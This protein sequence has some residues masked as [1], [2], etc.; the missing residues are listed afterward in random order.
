MEQVRNGPMAGRTV[1]VTGGTAGI[2]RA[3]ALGLATMGAHLAITCRDRGRTEGAPRAR[4]GEGA[5]IGCHHGSATSMVSSA[6]P[7]GI[8]LGPVSPCLRRWA[9]IRASQAAPR[10]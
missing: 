10:A 8:A 1:L 6:T 5:A 7:T 4:L 2:G 3:T 9:R